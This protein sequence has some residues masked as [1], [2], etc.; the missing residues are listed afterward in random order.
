[1]ARV[2]ESLFATL[3]FVLCVG[4]FYVTSELILEATFKITL[5]WKEYLKGIFI[6]LVRVKF[7]ILENNNHLKKN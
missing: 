2:Q 1:M 5:L 7:L 6:F 3:L 4:K